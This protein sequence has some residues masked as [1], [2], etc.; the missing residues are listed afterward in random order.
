MNT[1]QMYASNYEF[2]IDTYVMIRDTL[3]SLLNMT[4]KSNDRSN[5]SFEKIATKYCPTINRTLR[6]T[7]IPLT[8]KEVYNLIQFSI[9]KPNYT[10]FQVAL[11]ELVRQG[12][13]YPT[14]LKSYD[15]H[16]YSIVY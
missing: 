12:K 1:L 9:E 15:V 3:S 7:F 13:V 5:L 11:S 8:E 16:K 10:D 14:K 2:S 6:L 4:S